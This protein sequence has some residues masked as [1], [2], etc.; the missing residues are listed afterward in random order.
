MTTKRPT[1]LDEP[2][3]AAE[4]ELAAARN[5]CRS[6]QCQSMSLG[7]G[8]VRSDPEARAPLLDLGLDGD[9]AKMYLEELKQRRTEARA[10]IGGTA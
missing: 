9:A 4:R 2:M 7:Q 3:A 6:R 1:D 5:R 8:H 10:G